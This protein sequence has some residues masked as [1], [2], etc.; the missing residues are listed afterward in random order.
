MAKD[1]KINK[2]WLIFLKDVLA[3]LS[4]TSINTNSQIMPPGNDSPS[5]RQSQDFRNTGI[6]K[7]MAG[8]ETLFG[9]PVLMQNNFMRKLI[10]DFLLS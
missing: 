3:P 5:T 9:S 2:D 6:W 8:L 10:V 7:Y 4:Y 1:L